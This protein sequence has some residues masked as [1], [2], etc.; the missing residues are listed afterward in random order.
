MLYSS[1]LLAA[2]RD[3]VSAFCWPNRELLLVR[4]RQLS[5]G[6]YTRA[7]FCRCL[8]KTAMTLLCFAGVSFFL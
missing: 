2:L 4:N 7:V 1:T 8:T 3:N 6:A 5:F